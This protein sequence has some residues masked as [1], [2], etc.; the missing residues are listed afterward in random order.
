MGSRVKI[1]QTNR[2]T[3]INRDYNFIYY[4]IFCLN[5][6]CVL[7]GEYKEDISAYFWTLLILLCYMSLDQL[8]KACSL[9]ELD[10]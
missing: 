3:D 10:L 6:I 4:Y 1:V 7:L 2:Q 8:F 5:F 9:K